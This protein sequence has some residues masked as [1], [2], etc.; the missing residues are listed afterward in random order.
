M[1]QANGVRLE[2]LTEPER[3]QVLEALTAMSRHPVTD[4]A[5]SKT[6][7]KSADAVAASSPSVNTNGADKAAKKSETARAKKPIGKNQKEVVIELA[8]LSG[9]GYPSAVNLDTGSG[10]PAAVAQARPTP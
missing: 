1:L 9:K 2:D 10:K 4:S 8:A 6:G 5:S 3:T 7:S